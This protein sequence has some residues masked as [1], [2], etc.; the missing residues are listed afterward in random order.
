MFS[1]VGGRR[2][3][4][5]Q[6]GGD[7][8][9]YRVWNLIKPTR[10]IHLFFFKFNWLREIEWIKAVEEKRNSVSFLFPYKPRVR[11]ERFNSSLIKR[12][13]NFIQPLRLHSINITKTACTLLPYSI[14][15]LIKVD[16]TYL[17]TVILTAS[18]QY[19]YLDMFYQVLLR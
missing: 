3:L 16:T 2:H 11:K 13:I 17:R 15:D 12:E 8:K 14:L 19:M 18:R 4:S 9:R 7:F 10:F 6:I 5:S 1:I